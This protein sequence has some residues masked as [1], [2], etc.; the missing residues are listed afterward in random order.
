MGHVDTGKTKILD[1]VKHFITRFISA[2]MGGTWKV[3]NIDF[4]Y[5][6]QKC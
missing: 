5:A 2:Y 1:K 4:N 3:L 6:G